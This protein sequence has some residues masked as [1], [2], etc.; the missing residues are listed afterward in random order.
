MAAETKKAS[1]ETSISLTFVKSTKGTHV[2]SN[3]DEGMSN[4][5]FPK[6]LAV[7]NGADVEP[8]KSLIMT[9]KVSK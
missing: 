8:P 7:F 4:V 5:Y 2:F 3:M 1:T 9:L 6:D